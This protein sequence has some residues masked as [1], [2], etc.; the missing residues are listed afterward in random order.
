MKA[1]FG[2]HT[3]KSQDVYL[4]GL[5]T[6]R[7]RFSEQQ[8]PLSPRAPRAPGAFHLSRRAPNSGRAMGTG[9]RGHLPQPSTPPLRG[10]NAAIPWGK[11]GQKRACAPR[12]RQTA[13]GGRTARKPHR[14]SPPG[15]TTRPAPAARLQSHCDPSGRPPRAAAAVKEKLRLA[16]LTDALAGDADA[17]ATCSV[18]PLRPEHSKRQFPRGTKIPERPAEL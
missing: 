8:T 15:P 4:S 11:R 6:Q 3:Q 12:P 9:T 16:A 13:V 5:I 14:R 17:R 7:E 10:P 2:D 18:P 1:I